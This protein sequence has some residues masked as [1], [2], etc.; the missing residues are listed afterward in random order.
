[1]EVRNLL[2]HCLVL[3]NLVTPLIGLKIT[4]L[5][6]PS[7]ET[8]PSLVAEASIAFNKTKGSWRWGTYCPIVWSSSAW[9]PPL[10]RLKSHH[11]LDHHWKLLLPW[12]QLLSTQFSS[13]QQSFL[14]WIFIQGNLLARNVENIENTLYYSALVITVDMMLMVT[15][16]RKVYKDQDIE[17]NSTLDICNTSFLLHTYCIVIELWL[18]LEDYQSACNHRLLTSTLLVYRDTIFLIINKALD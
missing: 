18:L 6:A 8:S 3:I 9:S 1:M 13:S 2:S 7:V 14:S 15:Q 5:S 12:W 16:D 10:I 11:S 17:E 4:S